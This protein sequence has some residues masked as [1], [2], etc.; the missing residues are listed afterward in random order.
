MHFPAE[1]EESEPTQAEVVSPVPSPPR[2]PE[3]QSTDRPLSWNFDLSGFDVV[4]PTG[5]FPDDQGDPAETADR[6]EGRASIRPDQDG[7][8]GPFA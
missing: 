7:V 4:G 3:V 8:G 1:P 2:A 6:G 5:R